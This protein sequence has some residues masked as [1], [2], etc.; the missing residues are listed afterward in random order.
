VADGQKKTF[1][2]APSQADLRPS[3]MESH[4]AREIMDWQERSPKPLRVL[5]EPIAS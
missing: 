1:V 4:L 3:D 5:G 2:T